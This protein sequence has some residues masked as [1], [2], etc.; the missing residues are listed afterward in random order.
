MSVGLRHGLLLAG[1]LS[2]AFFLF[3]AALLRLAPPAATVDRGESAS[4]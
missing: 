2:T 3:A 4:S 1:V